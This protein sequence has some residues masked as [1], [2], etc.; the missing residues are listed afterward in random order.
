MRLIP[1]NRR[2][3][4]RKVEEGD[5]S[6]SDGIIIPTSAKKDNDSDSDIFI[7]VDRA[8]DT[9]LIVNQGNLVLVEKNMVEKDI[10]KFNGEEHEFLTVLENYVK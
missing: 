5:Q 6:R 9:K 2:V 4:V 7:V 3:V 8:L 1:K 10:V